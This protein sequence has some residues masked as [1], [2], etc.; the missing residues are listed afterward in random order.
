MSASRASLSMLD[1]S[2]RD[3]SRPM[4]E[5][6]GSDHPAAS[7][8]PMYKSLE[9]LDVSVFLARWRCGAPHSAVVVV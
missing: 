1:I 4:S 8:T 6:S 2:S 5:S 9:N 7:K 3:D